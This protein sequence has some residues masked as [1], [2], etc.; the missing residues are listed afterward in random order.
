MLPGN[1][2]LAPLLRPRVLLITFDPSMR[3]KGGKKLSKALG[4]RSAKDLCRDFIAD[5]FECSG[6]YLR[7]EIVEQVE[8]NAW[9]VK[10]DGFCYDETGF[11]E[12]WRSKTG[13][14]DPD[15]VDYEAIVADFDLLTRVEAGQIDEAWLFAFPY[16]GFYESVM[17][18]PGA[19]WCNAPPVPGTDGIPRRFVIMGFN[20][21][22]G[23]GSML[24]SFG[25]R[26]EAHL[27][28]TWRHQTGEDNLWER[29]IR[30][31]KVSPGQANC[32]WMH[33][34]PNSLTDYDWGNPSKVLSNCDDW[35]NFPSFQGTVRE[36]DCSEWGNGDMRAHHKWW[37]KHLP[38]AAAH[39]LGISNNWWWYGVDPN[40]VP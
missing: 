38:R 30:Y 5:L 2:G 29:F 12:C 1:E 39:T 36:V 28:H 16:A 40:A 4:W 14:H 24:E 35:L 33:Y 17:A 31:D 11:L 32:G 23:V 26:V 10:V 25:H 19:F 3:H 7:Y 9:P 20:Y 27:K 37:F 21:E 22:R 15:T 18:G 8:V 34:A 13:W 6:G